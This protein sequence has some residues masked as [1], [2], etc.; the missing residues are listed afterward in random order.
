MS[1]DPTYL[2]VEGLRLGD[3]E[4]PGEIVEGIRLD[5]PVYPDRVVVETCGG[6]GGKRSGEAIVGLETLEVLVYE[7]L[8]STVEVL[9]I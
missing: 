4:Y 1:L 5:T 6:N 8:E 2:A 3:P 9:G 7:D